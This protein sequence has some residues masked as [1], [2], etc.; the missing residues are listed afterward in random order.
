[1]GGEP[2]SSGV[3]LRE[4]RRD[5][6]PVDYEA[7]TRLWG[8]AGLAYRPNGRDRAERVLVELE[9]GT[10]LFLLAEVDGRPVGVVVATHD[11]RKGWIN[12]L[13]VAPAYRRRGI[14]ALLVREAETRLAA[15]GMDITAAL[16]ET[17]NRASLAFFES[18]GYVHDPHIEYVSKRA[19]PDT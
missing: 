1:M 15:A 8:D 9:R 19:S 12:R 7:V 16:I 18:I 3:A 17:P 6:W 13:A 11:G 2:S 4:L 10:A 14:A 5:D